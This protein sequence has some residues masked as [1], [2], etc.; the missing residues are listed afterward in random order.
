MHATA[1][2][3]PGA[4]PVDENFVAR[5][6]RLKYKPQLVLKLN[7]ANPLAS[8][9]MMHTS[10][11]SHS[12]HSSH[13]SSSGGGH[14]SHTSH[15]SHYSSSTYTPS[16]GSSTPSY[17]TPSYSTPSYFSPSKPATRR[18]STAKKVVKTTT[19][20]PQSVT[21][22]YALGDRVLKLGDR[23]LDVTAL[24]QLL[25]VVNYE[26]TASGVFGLAT[27]AAVKDFQTAHG[28]PAD[29]VV[30]T[31]TLRALQQ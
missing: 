19:V 10:H 22:T 8:K 23:G 5:L 11:R 6:R 14:S 25:I 26:I 29:G 3:S 21:T 9:A 12:S 1:A 30:G 31:Q 15:S 27:N 4:L 7:M 2:T 17:S 16:S 24:Q 20:Y 13:Y 28:L 18:R